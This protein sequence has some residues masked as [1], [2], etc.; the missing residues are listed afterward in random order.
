[1]LSSAFP[2]PRSRT[3]RFQNRDRFIDHLSNSCWTNSLGHALQDL[4][5]FRYVSFDMFEDF[6]DYKYNKGVY[7]YLTRYYEWLYNQ[8]RI[9]TSL[10]YGAN[11]YTIS[12][13]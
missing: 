9:S 10:L 7:M 4:D 11:I 3:N 2:A 6:E 12:E 1:M 8:A 13:A 5:I